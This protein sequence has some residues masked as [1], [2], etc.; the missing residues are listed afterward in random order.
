M[1]RN[2]LTITVVENDFYFDLLC[3]E[4][5]KDLNVD[6]RLNYLVER[7]NNSLGKQLETLARNVRQDLLHEEYLKYPVL[8]N[9]NLDGVF[10]ED[11][12]IPRLSKKELRRALYLEL[13]KLYGDFDSKFVYSVLLKSASKQ[14]Y[15]LKVALFNLETYRHLLDFLQETRLKIERI[16]LAPD[17]LKNFILNRKM[18]FRPENANLIINMG[19]NF[20]TLIGI[21]DKS[22]IAHQIVH[23]GYKTFSD[24]FVE[25]LEN[26]VNGDLLSPA[27]K[28]EVKRELGGLMKEVFRIGGG[29]VREA[30]VETY[31]YVEDEIEDR[32]LKAI[33]MSYDLQI[34][35]LAA[36]PYLKELL[37]ISALT[38]AD[39]NHDFLFPARLSDEKK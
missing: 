17:N 28:K 25:L 35:K 30:Q 32:L 20:S 24:K 26:W 34:N 27:L 3:V 38:K 10:I 12:E 31:L 15:N 6:F 16:S 39:R 29:M 23:C 36:Q 5:Q 9:L 7:N 4:K 13:A 33:T 22:V 1:K 14:L 18:V 37:E 8:V 19:K 11:L 2:I 21:K